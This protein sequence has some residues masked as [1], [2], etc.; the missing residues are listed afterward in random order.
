MNK[1][2]IAVWCKEK[3]VQEDQRILLSESITLGNGIRK[4]RKIEV[5]VLEY[6]LSK[7]IYPCFILL[8]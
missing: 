7:T 2:R 5:L 8:I 4:I 1:M 3:A 6:M